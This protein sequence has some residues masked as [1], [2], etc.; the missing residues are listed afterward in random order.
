MNQKLIAYALLVPIFLVFFN[1]FV[2]SSVGA[3]EDVAANNDILSSVTYEK[4]NPKDG[5]RYILKRLKEKTT[6]LLFSI[7]TNKTF[8]YKKEL[9][10]KRMA[11]LKQVVDTKDVANIEVVSQR[12]FSTAGDLTKFTIDKASDSQKEDL[13]SYLNN[14]L[15]ILEAL[16]S[17]YDDPTA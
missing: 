9:L 7:S 10:A 3:Q 14:N 16:N 5:Y 17:Q 15:K 12:Y 11:E 8:E 2:L 13:R 1:L 4:I 6:L